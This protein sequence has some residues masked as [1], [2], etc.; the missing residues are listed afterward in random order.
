M[1]VLE[2]SIEQAVLAWFRRL[3]PLVP[4]TKMNGM[5]MRSWPDRC[6]WIPGGKPFLIEFK[7]LGAKQTPL[8]VIT[9][10]RLIKQGYDV[11]VHDTIEGAKAALKRRMAA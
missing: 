9:M 11:E 2:K 4:I 3:W 8:Q 5:G 10:E 7:R 6:F 1:R